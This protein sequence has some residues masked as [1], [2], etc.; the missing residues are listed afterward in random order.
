MAKAPSSPRSKTTA[1]AGAPTDTAPPAGTPSHQIWLAGLGAM[2]QAQAQGTKAFEALVSDGL[3]FQRKSQAEA[4]QRLHEATERFT[5]LAQDFGQQASGRIDRLEH[6]FEDR[7]AK[8][9]QRLGIPSLHDL[10][11]L[12]ARIEALEARLASTPKATSPRPKATTAAKT[13]STRKAR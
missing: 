6:V 5:H 13:P 2:A 4:Q 1:P 12:N 7:V 3:A 9:L 8:A 10:E 11:Q